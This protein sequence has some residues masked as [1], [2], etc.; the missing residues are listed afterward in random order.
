MYILY[1]LVCR[2]TSAGYNLTN[3]FVGS[4]GTLGFITQTTVKLYGVPEAVSACLINQL[5]EY[6]LIDGYG[7]VSIQGYL[8]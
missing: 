4:E 6:H 3:V 8:V 1:L 2:K 7:V 5:T